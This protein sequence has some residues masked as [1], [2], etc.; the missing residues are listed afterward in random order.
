MENINQFLN[1][2]D[3]R[4]IFLLIWSLIWKG[5]ALWRAAQDKQKVWFIAILIVNLF[6]ILE[7]V[8]LLFFQ[9]KEKL[10]RKLFLK[11]PKKK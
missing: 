5:L 2:N 8:Y 6:G 10:W 7:I 1:I 3:P 9:K 11:A 4:F